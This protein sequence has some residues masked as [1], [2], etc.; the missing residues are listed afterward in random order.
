MAL[1]SFIR[2]AIVSLAVLIIGS[3]ATREHSEVSATSLGA[4][5]EVTLS[6]LA[7]GF[8]ADTTTIGTFAAPDAQFAATIGFIPPAFGIGTLESETGDIEINDLIG[9]LLSRSNLGI[10]TGTNGGGCNAP[11][12]VDFDLLAASVDPSAAASTGF[13]AEGI[14][15]KAIVGAVNPNGSGENDQFQ[16]LQDD[17]GDYN[18]DGDTLDTGAPY[19]EPGVGNILIDSERMLIRELDTTSSPNTLTVMRGVAGTAAATHTNG[20]DIFQ[21]NAG[22][23]DST[24]DLDEAVDTTETLIDVT[25]A[26]VFTPGGNGIQ[27]GVERWPNYLI[28]TFDF[29]GNGVADDDELPLF[30]AIGIVDVTSTTVALNFLLFRPGQLQNARTAPAQQMVEALG[31]PNVTI[32]QD[33]GAPPQT[34]PITDFCPPVLTKTTTCGTVDAD[35]NFANGCTASAKVVRTNPAA[36]TGVAA[37]APTNTHIFYTYNVTTRDFDNDGIDGTLDTCWNDPDND[38]DGLVEDISDRDRDGISDGPDPT[39][40]NPRFAVAGGDIDGDLLTNGCDPSPATN[41]GSGDHDLDGFS[42]PLDNCPRVPNVNQ[43]GGSLSAGSNV[44]LGLLKGG[45][46][47]QAGGQ[48]SDFGPGTDSIGA[49]CDDSDGDGVEGAGTCTDG[50]DN[51]GDGDTDGND[52]DCSAVEGTGTTFVDGSC[53]D[54]ADNDNDGLY[55]TDD[56]DCQRSDGVDLVDTD[57]DN[58]GILDVDDDTA[59]I[60]N[61]HYHKELL[62]RP[63]CIDPTTNADTDLDGWCDLTEDALGSD[64]LINPAEIGADC[65]DDVDDDSD[66]YVNDGCPVVGRFAEHGVQCTNALNDDFPAIDEDEATIIVGGGPNAINDGCPAVGGGGAESACG[67]DNVDDDLDGFV[68]DGCPPDGDPETGAECFNNVTD[69]GDSDINE[70]CPIAYPIPGVGVPENSIVDFGLDPVVVTCSDGVDNDGDTDVDDADGNCSEDTDGDSA[71]CKAPSGTFGC[72]TSEG[73]FLGDL[74]EWFLG[75]DHN[76]AC[77]A[78]A[79]VDD[80]NTDAHGLDFDD[81]GDSDGSDVSLFADRFGQELGQP[82]DIGRT[83]YSVRFDIFPDFASPMGSGSRGKIDGSDVSIL[84]QYFGVVS[85]P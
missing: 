73:P 35:A 82:P 20:T 21:V 66:G 52:L 53:D 49:A 22:T 31:Y 24:A 33:P 8:N 12:A 74:V 32:L 36:N 30:R 27:D 45:G 42:N 57:D 6:S 71:G 18:N 11:T 77:P 54:N 37:S 59:A 58:D 48:S 9:K 26:S 46:D 19:F 25:D 75:T 34:S 80:E 63:V 55:D 68:N 41:E 65:E 67:T 47:I 14:I 23:V 10:F 83:E 1:S 72:G 61:G 64:D 69:D 29:N 28:L 7:H 4:N 44:P 40:F 43:S 81:D 62:V 13:N 78:N 56:P 17:D 38:G 5:N 51:D 85:C 3:V 39:P 50:L 16:P 84:A 70:G 60:P 15:D 2:L 79:V 76:Q